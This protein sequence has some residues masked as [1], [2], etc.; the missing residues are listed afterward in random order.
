MLLFTAIG[1]LFVAALADRQDE[2]Y[3]LSGREHARKVGPW[4]MRLQGATQGL[5]EALDAEDRPGVVRGLEDVWFW[6]GRVV[7]DAM[8]ASEVQGADE[9]TG[10]VGAAV[11]EAYKVAG[12]AK[13]F[14]ATA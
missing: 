13:R 1:V 10:A 14:L 5:Q 7:C 3:G 8:S 2:R 12:K 9:L 4:V 6:V 11:L